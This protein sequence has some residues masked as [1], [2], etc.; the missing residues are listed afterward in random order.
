MSQVASR[1]PLSHRWLMAYA[2]LYIV[3]LYLP[4]LFLPVFSFN[5][6][7]IA[8]FPLTGFTTRWYV[9]LAGN[10]F[11]HAAIANSLLVAVVTAVVATA[12]HWLRFGTYRQCGGVFSKTS[13]RAPISPQSWPAA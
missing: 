8:S 7:T 5:D 12:F 2:V 13:I 11:L 10:T 4:V 6:A 3:F 1:S 9:D